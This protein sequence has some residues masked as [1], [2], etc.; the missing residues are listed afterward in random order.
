MATLIIGLLIGVAIPVGW[1]AWV[2]WKH[3]AN[4]K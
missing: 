2:A 4:R 3:Y 1:L